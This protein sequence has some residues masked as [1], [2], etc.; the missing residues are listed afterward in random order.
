LLTLEDRAQLYNKTW[1][2]RYPDSRLRVADPL[3]D[4]LYGVWFLGNTYRT[5]K[6]LYGAYPYGYLP[7]ITTLFPDCKSVLHLFSGSLLR[8]PYVRFDIK[9]KADV[10][11]DAHE[12]GLYFL[13]EFDLIYADPPYH[14]QAAA[15]YGTPMPNRAKVMRECYK[16]L[17][18]GGFVVWLDTV[19][20]IARKDQLKLVGCIPIIRSQNHVLRAAFISQRV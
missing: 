18:P 11:G 13:P 17:K 20:P 4:K 15:I 19:W 8:G 5:G 7:R 10:Q 3:T 16:V 14:K 1:G 6:S 9:N 2:V 12:L